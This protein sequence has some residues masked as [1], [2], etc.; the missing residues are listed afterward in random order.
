MAA[1]DQ[2][3]IACLRRAAEGTITESE[4]DDH[5][6]PWKIETKSPPSELILREVEHFWANLRPWKGPR[7]ILA[8]DRERLRILAKAL[9][10]G[11]DA[12]RTEKEVDEW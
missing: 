4:F 2:E 6:R 5:F 1:T 9:E 7:N 11:W 3:M 10:G 12:A 8:N